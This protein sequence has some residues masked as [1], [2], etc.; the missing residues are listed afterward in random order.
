MR[1][2]TKL[3]KNYLNF[4]SS[5]VT[6]RSLALKF[7]SGNYWPKINDTG[8]SVSSPKC[9]NISLMKVATFFPSIYKFSAWVDPPPKNN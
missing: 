3:V 8:S 7:F 9:S 1:F 2:L 5:W 4:S 6:N